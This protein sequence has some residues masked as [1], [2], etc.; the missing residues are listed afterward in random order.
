MGAR[1]CVGEG[2]F[3]AGNR[4]MVW[5]TPARQQTFGQCGIQEKRS[6][7]NLLENMAK[8]NICS[9]QDVQFHLGCEEHSQ[10]EVELITG[11]PAASQS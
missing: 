1:R 11:W 2:Y 7:R 9:G 5:T 8:I 6:A 10:L 3:L 4:M